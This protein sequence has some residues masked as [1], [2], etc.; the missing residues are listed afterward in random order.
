MENTFGVIL[1]ALYLC[2]AVFVLKIA[3]K[4]YEK[5]LDRED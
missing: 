5:N 2:V 3:F 1:F 4:V